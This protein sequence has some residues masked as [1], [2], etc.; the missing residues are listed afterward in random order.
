M[1]QIGAAIKRLR[2]ERGWTQSQLG[3]LLGLDHTSIARRENGRTRVKAGER[4]V[5]AKAFGMSLREFDEAWR[6]WEATR[7]RGGPGIPVINRAPAGQIVDY[8]EYGVDSGQG[9]EYLDWGDVSDRLA[10]AVVVCG[11]SMEP[12]LSDGDQLVL[13]PVDPYRA[14]GKLEDGKI[15]FVRFTAEHGGGCTLARFFSGLDGSVELR[16]DNRAYRVIECR[17]EDVERVAVAIERRVKL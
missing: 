2:E 5:F 11:D 12:T 7:T 1:N 17:R 8:E 6:E 14:D 9:M 13:S 4:P 10:F 3:A 15:V 16:K